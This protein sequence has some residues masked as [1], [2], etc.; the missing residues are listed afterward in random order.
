MKMKMVGI[1]VC[2]LLTTSIL[3]ITGLVENVSAFRNL[4]NRTR[5]PI[6][7]DDIID[8]T[9]TIDCGY[10]WWVLHNVWE[11][12]GFVPSLPILT[13]VRLYMF[14]LGTPATSEL[15]VSIRDDLTGD[16]LTEI[17]GYGI[18]G[19]QWLEFDFPDIDVDIGEEYYIVCRASEGNDMENCYCWF[20]G[21]NDPYPPG[22]AWYSQNYGSSWIIRE[23]LPDFP[24]NDFCFETYGREQ[25]YPNPPTIDGPTEGVAGEEYNY[26]FVTIDLEGEDVWYW[27]VWGDG[28]PAIEWIGPYASGEEIILSHIFEEQGNFQIS[29]KAK[30]IHDAE[31]P[32]G[33][34]D[35]EMPL[36]FQIF[37]KNHHLL[38][39]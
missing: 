7:D 31:G 19:S 12:Q 11:A 4:N 23:Y 33:Y 14:E 27:I 2:M 35:V 34:L 15:V 1:V 26:S 30:D 39:R 10:G 17:I 24:E 22:E 28:C 38:R 6:A 3:S 9:Q 16:D 20:F 21:I 5:I 25:W 36:S 29:A 32:W 18:S 13:R 8:Q 37:I